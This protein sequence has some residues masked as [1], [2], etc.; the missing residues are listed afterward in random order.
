[1]KIESISKPN[2]Y[3]EFIKDVSS[4]FYQSAKHLKFLEKILKIKTEFIVAKDDNIMV[5]VMPFFSKKTKFGT[6]INSLPFFGSY[7][8][9]ISN[10]NEAKK[11][12]LKFLNQY[13]QESDILS[14]VI[15]SNPF[16]NTDV[17]EK[18]FKFIDKSERLIQCLNL[19]NNIEENLWNGFEQRVRRGIRKA[20]KNMVTV[21]HS[22][23]TDKLLKKFYNH[24]VKN[25]SIKNGAIKPKGFFKEV[26]E[27][28]KIKEDYGILTAK[29]K[30]EPIAHL[31]VFYFKSFTEYY[32]PAYDVEKSNLQGT[33]LLIWESIKHAL[34]KKMEFYNFGGTHKKDDSLYN[35]KKGWNTV[36]LH[37]NY[38]TYA[39]LEKLE[40]IGK[41][42]LKTVF[43]YFYVYNYNK[44]LN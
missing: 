34:T 17:Y 43:D 7:G 22:E 33:S 32:M 3:D 19:K 5:G 4:T 41:E 35:F 42:E 20:K 16:K 12:I 24:H 6:V 13:N 44:I 11:N 18:H 27:N 38:Y 31:L 40:E 8:G 9:I 14:S 37:Y 2:E 25:I 21:E 30:S 36:D 10:E 26:I 15:I 23:P 39:N 28:F 29:Y 1:M